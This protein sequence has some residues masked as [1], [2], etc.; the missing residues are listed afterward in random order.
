MSEKA[1]GFEKYTPTRL[2][3]LAVQLNGVLPIRL[4]GTGLEPLFFAGEDG[5]TLLM[6]VKSESNLT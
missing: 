1:P 6:L 5:K 2:D 4:Q 3:W